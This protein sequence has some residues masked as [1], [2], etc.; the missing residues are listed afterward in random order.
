L[1]LYLIRRSLIPIN[2]SLL[3][4]KQRYEHAVIKMELTLDAA[5]KK[6]IEAHK[7]GKAREA[8]SYYTSILRPI[9]NTMMLITI[10]V[11]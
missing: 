7:A 2:L 5:L 11:S 1:K 6:G 4:Y 3:N 8:D 10:W 9:P